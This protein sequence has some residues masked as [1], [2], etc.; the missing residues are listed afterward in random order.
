MLEVT[1]LDVFYGDLQALWDVSLKLEDGEIVALIGANGA[2]KSTLLNTISGLLNPA[3]GQILLDGIR[4]DK[5]PAHERTALGIAMVPEGRRV[6]PE[7]TVGENLE[8]GA[9]NP[10]ARKIRAQTIEWVFT[11]FPIL[12]Q[13]INQH[14]IT[15][16]GGE[17]QMLAIGRALMA[18]PK[19]LLVDE[20]SLGLSPLL[21][22]SIFKVLKEINKS[23]GLTIFVVEQNVRMALDVSS[24]G[25][26]LETGH[27]VG[28]DT[29]AALIASDNVKEAYL[30]LAT[31]ENTQK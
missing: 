9:F 14:A 21:A 3:R 17:Q 24:H 22:Q 8:M 19:Y 20:A 5:K 4:I 27:I 6:F 1:N 2:G 26:I 29:A 30:G 11:V 10:R 15:L 31:K 12:K 7:M 23:K 18:E 16:S 25:Y 28:H 13:R